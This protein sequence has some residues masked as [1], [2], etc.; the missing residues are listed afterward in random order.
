MS[1]SFHQRFYLRNQGLH[2]FILCVK[3]S[4]LHVF[5]CSLHPLVRCS[6]LSEQ[7]SCLLFI[8]QL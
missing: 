5:V 7:L 6:F 4:T 3:S 1:D 8:Y 2:F